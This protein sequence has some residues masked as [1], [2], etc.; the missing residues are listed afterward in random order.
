MMRRAGQADPLSLSARIS[1]VM[2]KPQC[3]YLVTRRVGHGT[4]GRRGYRLLSQSELHDLVLRGKSPPGRGEP[5]QAASLAR[6]VTPAPGEYRRCAWPHWVPNA[7]R[8]RGTPIRQDWHH[9]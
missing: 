9:G 1:L 2:A 6:S 8:T 5:G 7:V 3:V 4:R